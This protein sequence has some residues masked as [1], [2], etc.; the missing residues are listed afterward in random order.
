MI[1]YTDLC[2]WNSVGTVS[3][4][5]LMLW[6]DHALNEVHRTCNKTVQFALDSRRDA[7]ALIQDIRTHTFMH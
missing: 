3:Y 1:Y 5:C 7:Q 4:V 6:N 2:I